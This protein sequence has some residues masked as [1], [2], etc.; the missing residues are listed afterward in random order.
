MSQ[1]EHHDGTFTAPDG[2]ELYVQSWVSRDQP[3]RG[4]MGIVHGL[5]EHSG[6]YEHVVERLVPA[7]FAV[8]GFDLRGH[9]RSPGQR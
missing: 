5:G 1:I 7:G 8:Y 4:V 2:L 6:E 9:G 3:T